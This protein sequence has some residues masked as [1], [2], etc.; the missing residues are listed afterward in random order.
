MP[1]CLGFM[2]TVWTRERE[3]REK[4]RCREKP[5]R[6]RSVRCKD[7]DRGRRGIGR[8]R[9]NG[10]RYYGRRAYIPSPAF[11]VCAPCGEKAS[12]GV[13]CRARC[14]SGRRER[15]RDKG[16]ASGGDGVLLYRGIRRARYPYVV[17]E[18]PVNV[19]DKGGERSLSIGEIATKCL[20]EERQRSSPFLPAPPRLRA[21]P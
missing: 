15:V 19:G 14:V 4:E 17:A 9:N 13:V 1:E 11:V 10:S 6:L 12:A 7:T 18:W 16:D 5:T 21:S 2:H 8:A 20:S 3:G